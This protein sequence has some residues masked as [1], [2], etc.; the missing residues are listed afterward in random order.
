M[1]HQ[2][3]IEQLYQQHSAFMRNV[4]RSKV[5]HQMEYYDLIEDCI[6][7]T[8]LTASQAYK[9]L[10]RHPNPRGWLLKTCMNRMMTQLRTLRYQQRFQ[11]FSMDDPNSPAVA[12]EEGMDTFLRQD[13]ARLILARIEASLTKEERMVFYDYFGKK[14]TMHDVATVH[15]LT[16]EQV[17]NIIKRI[18]RK[19]NAMQI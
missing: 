4:C 5:N 12:D 15:N 14:N 6:Q 8:F 17:K 10:K 19:V 7:E 2:H 11:A 13:E 9:T 1:P 3:F 16:D 18:R